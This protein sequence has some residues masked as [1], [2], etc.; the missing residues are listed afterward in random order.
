MPL[1]L[2]NTT[3]QGY[4]IEIFAMEVILSNRGLRI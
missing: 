3:S 2:N 4:L 1:P